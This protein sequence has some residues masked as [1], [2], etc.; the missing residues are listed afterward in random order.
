MPG[1]RKPHEGFPLLLRRRMR[2]TEPQAKP[3]PAASNQDQEE[4][5]RSAPCPWIALV[6]SDQNG[7][8]RGQVAYKGR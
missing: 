5:E 1:T 4:E 2:L 3:L 7:G 6:L 8:P